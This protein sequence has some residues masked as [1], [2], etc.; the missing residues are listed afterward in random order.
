[1]SQMTMDTIFTNPIV[2]EY[3]PIDLTVQK[4]YPNYYDRF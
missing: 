1:M 2:W 3:T 4:I